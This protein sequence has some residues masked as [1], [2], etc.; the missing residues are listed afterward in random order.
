MSTVMTP[1]ESG[2]NSEAGPPSGRL[3]RRI[4]WHL[5]HNPKRELWVAWWMMV[6]FY[7]LFFSVFFLVTQ[8]Q[9]PPQPTWDLATQVHWFNERHLGIPIGFGI[10]FAIA[11]LT[12]VNNA[13]IAYSMRRMS[14]SR[15][16]GYRICSCTR[17]AR[18]PA[19]CCCA[20]R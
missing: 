16:F 6:V 17:S 1:P 18:F 4:A 13:L 20:S 8:V 12:A 5:R 10:I 19:C 2:S 14:V 3:H 11:G 7:N 15:A 9:P